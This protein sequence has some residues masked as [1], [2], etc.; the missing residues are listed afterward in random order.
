MRFRFRRSPA[1]IV[2]CA[3]LFVALGGTATAVTYVVSSNSQVG[4]NTIS[5]HHPPSG[6]HANLIAG[7]VGSRDV[8]DNNLTGADIANRSGVD[9]CQTPKVGKF[10]PICAGSDGNQRTWVNAMDYCTASRL[11]LPSL[12]EAITLAKGFDVPGIGATGTFWA[13]DSSFDPQTLNEYAYVVDENGN[14]A[15]STKNQASYTVCVTD[16]SA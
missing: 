13:D 1:M 12:S 5:G 7:S 10:G 4:P 14:Y 3:A 6:K 11:R 8:A 16:P 15:I 2:A 9:T